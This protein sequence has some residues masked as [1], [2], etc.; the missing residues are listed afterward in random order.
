MRNAVSNGQKPSDS[1]SSTSMSGHLTRHLGQRP[2]AIAGP[3]LAALM[4]TLV[5]CLGG[6]GDDTASA[7]TITPTASYV[8]AT[9][10]VAVTGGT[11]AAAAD[12][13]ASLR[14]FKAIPF[15]APPVGA[16]RWKPPQAVTVWTG[17]RRSDSY[18]AAC[19][20]GTRPAGA[21][22]SI[23]YQQT[24]AQSE[25]CLYLN[26]WTGATAGANEQRPVMLLI[27][28]GGYQLGAGSQP[29]YNGSGLAAKGAVVVT[30][31]YRLGAL[32]FLAHPA[33]T[34]ES[35]DAISGNYALLDVIAALNWVKNNIG[36]FGGNPNNVTVYSESAGSGIASVL[37][38]S[39]RAAGL[40]QRMML[41]SLGSMPAG[42]NSPTLAQAES[43]G[44]T[45]ATALGAATL[46]DLR[47]KS[48]QEVMA[49]ALSIVAP[50]VDGVV[51]P[52]QLDR[53]FATGAVH[54][55]PLLLGWNADEGT[56]YPPFATT[57]AAY[58]ATATARYGSLA[59]AFKAVYPAT[60]D[61]EVLAMA[62]APMRD[63]LFAWQP[64]TIA[65]AHAN[66][67]RAKTYLYHFN[68]R[69]PYYADQHFTQQD[70]PEKYGAYHSLEQVYF[71]NNLDRSAP[72]RP[73]TALDRTLASSASSYLINFARNGDP[74]G[75]GLATWPVF[76]GASSQA[77]ILGD[78]IAAGT[79]PFRPALDFYDT[80]YTQALG[81]A[82]PF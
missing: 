65:R 46:A 27:H 61:A 10:T 20:M 6:G 70:P 36:T 11:L 28:G 77:M 79:V 26:V 29:N 43:A 69:P 47:A 4:L 45:Y 71:Y 50:I 49:G 63:N 23:L 39:P 62:F 17:V 31:N 52:D 58:D 81:R 38:G 8:A 68:R 56:P 33:L 75:S 76:A 82:L 80:F 15:A 30:L 16:L 48:P 54:D 60:T 53:L 51:W 41:A 74:N 9:D 34:A 40:F 5:G 18:S 1:R 67:A 3:A 78:T 73:Y 22:G 2:L 32:G 25:D 37:L 72:P 44:S 35:A 64:W 66:L 13:S 24:E 57:L 14:V 42:S 19:Y 7:P 59:A 12:S 21:V 55:V